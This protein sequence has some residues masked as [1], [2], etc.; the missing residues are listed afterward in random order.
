VII[1][2]TTLKY[3]SSIRLREA[4][5]VSWKTWQPVTGGFSVRLPHDPLLSQNTD[6]GTDRMEY[7]NMLLLMHRRAATILL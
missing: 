3:F 6:Y 1:N 5:P 2:A 7:G 4:Q